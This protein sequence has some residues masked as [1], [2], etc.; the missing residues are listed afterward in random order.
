MPDV[1][2]PGSGDPGSLNS[3][4]NTGAT[5]N[6]MVSEETYKQLE[7]KLGE[8]GKELGDYN[9]YFESIKPVL[10]K[11]AEDTDGKLVHAILQGKLT[12]ELATAA[13]EGKLTMAEAKAIESVQKE[14][15]KEV[16]KATFEKMD[17]AEIERLVGERMK[18]VEEKIE[19]RLKEAEDDVEFSKGLD[20]FVDAHPDFVE[21][22]DQILEWL[23]K[24]D[25]LDP[26]AAYYA[27]KGELWE[28]LAAEEA[29]K[30][31]SERMKEVAMNAAGGGGSSAA[32]IVSDDILDQFI[33]PRT[34]TTNY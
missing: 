12:P 4:P 5:V 31:G 33:S 23:D 3:G 8:M 13:L 32:Q 14:V 9:T 18:L 26:S 28:R 1:N 22:K 15:Q 24:H 27:V 21:L 16:G 20:G 30:S 17:P 10:E 25:S 2:L 19:T 34:M 11:L 7:R 29:K 6:G